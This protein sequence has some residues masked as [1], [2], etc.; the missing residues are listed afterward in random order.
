MTEL[1]EDTESRN[2]TGQVFIG[3]LIILMFAPFL[4]E[5]INYLELKTLFQITFIIILILVIVN[6]L[7]IGKYYQLKFEM[8]LLKQKFKKIQ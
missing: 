2:F 5:S 3:I 1:E 7:V 8:K 6:V 4:W